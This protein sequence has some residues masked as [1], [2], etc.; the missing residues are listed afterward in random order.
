MPATDDAQAVVE[1]LKPSHGAKSEEESKEQ[2]RKEDEDILRRQNLDA[3]RSYLLCILCAS[4]STDARA[5]C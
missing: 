2:R 3:E 5:G 1:L 4:L